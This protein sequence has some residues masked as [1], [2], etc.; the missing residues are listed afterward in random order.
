MKRNRFAVVSCLFIFLA[1]PALLAQSHLIA[2]VPFD[3]TLDQKSMHSGQYDVRS[4]SEQVELL[5]NLDTDGSAFFAKSVRVQAQQ[6]PDAKLVF[7]KYGDKY[8]LSQVWD[9]NSDTGIELLM[10][11][12]E[13]EIR[14]AGNRFSASPE[15]VIVAMN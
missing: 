12:H 1:V 14:M 2:N 5:R 3:F 9:G 7:H 6:A 11:K 13:R 4:V 8:F 15:I 10:S